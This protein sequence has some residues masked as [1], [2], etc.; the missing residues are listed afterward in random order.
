MSDWT[1]A[2]VNDWVTTI[3]AFRPKVVSVVRRK[4]GGIMYQ[5]ILTM[6]PIP[7][8]A[9]EDQDG[10]MGKLNGTDLID[11]KRKDLMKKGNWEQEDILVAANVAAHLLAERDQ[12]ID[13]WLEKNEIGAD[14]STEDGEEKIELDS[15]KEPYRSAPAD[16][17]TSGPEHTFDGLQMPCFDGEH[18]KEWLETIT[19]LSAEDKKNVRKKFQEI[20]MDEALNDDEVG[21]TQ[22]TIGVCVAPLASRR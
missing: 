22:L 1:G 2:D 16:I 14:E 19:T 6:F 10:A 12:Y 21:V 8:D 5:K 3:P 4:F 13:R 17:D 15:E 9:P 20:K 7:D 11:L 18:V